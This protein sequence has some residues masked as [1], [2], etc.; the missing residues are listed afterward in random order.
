LEIGWIAVRG[1]TFSGA[2]LATL[3][4]ALATSLQCAR[5]QSLAGQQVRLVVPFPAGGPTDIV[6]RPL[7][8]MLGDA[9]KAVIVV[10]NRG[11][12]GGSLGAD[13]VAK[14]APDG[15]T[16][17]M[18]TV[19]T[20]AIN[21]TLYKSLSYDA[22]RDFTP[23]G[24]VAMAPVAIVVHPSQ[25]AN[26]V[27]DLVALAKR[28]PGKL[29]YGSAGAGTPGHLTGEIFKAAAGINIQHVP[30]RG[31]AP[32]VTDLLGGQIPIMFDPLQSILSNVQGGRLRAIAISSKGR[33]SVL[34]N[35]PTIAESGYAGFETTAWWAVFAPARLPTALAASL[36][37][38]ID[39]IIASDAFRSKLEPLGVLPTF[40]GGEKFVE[41][42]RSEIDKWGKAV[43]ESGATPD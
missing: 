8:Q 37:G 3:V 28:T 40:L 43:R 4:I 21:P 18:A 12:A 15:R 42:Q 32:A 36:T 16:L 25:P 14:S 11:G 9:T 27:A 35:V 13:A 26:T 19:G 22:V 5:A 2:C 20:H 23:I 41:F 30:Y 24:L 29:N 34:P 7:A 33:S 6:A 31:S 38:E 10:D 17:L 39:K 1:M